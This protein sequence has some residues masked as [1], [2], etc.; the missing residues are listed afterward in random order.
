MAA[1]DYLQYTTPFTIAYQRMVEARLDTLPV[2]D[3]LYDPL[4]AP[5]WFLP[6]LA[7]LVRADT[8]STLLG[9]TYERRAIQSAHYY[10]QYRGTKLAVD[11]FAQEAGF[12]YIHEFVRGPGLQ[13]S[14]EQGNYT[15]RNATFRDKTL[16][17]IT[18]N[19]N[20]IS[21]ELSDLTGITDWSGYT[22]YYSGNAY[23]LTYIDTSGNT[24]NFSV[25]GITLPANFNDLVISNLPRNKQRNISINL[26]VT[27]SIDGSISSNLWT[28]F[29]TITIA[30]LLPFLVSVNTITT[31][32]RDNITSYPAVLHRQKSI[33]Y[34]EV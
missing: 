8:Y 12:F 21:L 2:P 22:L 13:V 32:R 33:K 6:H 5:L 11:R 26:E 25:S 16:V 23:P 15:P 14:R 18:Q 10:N 27:P 28:E 1:L 31:A 29:I 30:K 19:G 3:H 7:C 24:V 20:T 17:G 34:L 9:E 4:R